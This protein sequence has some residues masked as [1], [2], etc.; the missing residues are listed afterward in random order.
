VSVA[1]DLTAVQLVIE[2]WNTNFPGYAVSLIFW[3][4]VI[5]ANIIVVSAYGEV[6]YWLSLLKVVT[7]VIFII[8][9][10]VVNC[11]A[12]TMHHYI[13]AHNWYIGDAPFVGG[14]GGFASVFVTA[15][16]ACACI[17]T[18]YLHPVSPSD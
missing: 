8:L 12:N 16:F 14:I 3:V 13:G 2:Y 4:A 15:S 9:S 7:I 6:E 18:P 5:A 10:I 11:G 1:S 17:Y